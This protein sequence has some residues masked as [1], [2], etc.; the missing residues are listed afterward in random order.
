MN[1]NFIQGEFHFTRSDR[2]FENF[3]AR[4]ER[5]LP[6]GLDA[7]GDPLL[8]SDD[9]LFAF[10]GGHDG[11]GLRADGAGRDYRGGCVMANTITMDTAALIWKAH[12]EIETSIKLLADIREK[13]KFGGDPN[14]LDAFGRHRP[15]TL[16]IPSGDAG[17]QLVGLSPELAAHIIEAHI[18]RKQSELVE[19]CARAALELAGDLPAKITT[20][21]TAS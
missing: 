1:D 13:K 17:H 7:R 15:Y 6:R 3:V 12:R 14:P 2:D 16:G 5:L 8:M 9:V 21:E 11:L 18:T 4:V 20:G 19:A 10:E